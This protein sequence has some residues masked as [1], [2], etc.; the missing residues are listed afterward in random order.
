MPRKVSLFAFLLTAVALALAGCG[1]GGGGDLPVEEL[2]INYPKAQEGTDSI[3]RAF[4]IKS[5]P[6]KSLN[7]VTL[8][9]QAGEAGDYTL[10]LEARA[11]TFDGTLIGQS[12]VSATLPDATTPS[13]P[14]TFTFGFQPVTPDT[15]VTFK[16]VKVSGPGGN[17]WFSVKGDYGELTSE[18]ILVIET[19][20][21]DPPLSS[22]RRD[23]I[24]I[25]VYGEK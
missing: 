24:A 3:N 2:L 10:Q 20:G 4:Y 22:W 18:E 21:T 5:Y 7:R 14:V 19:N 1:G 6:G 23:G 9:F 13:A 8:W 25:L 16:M 12:T 11:G 17:V 15:V